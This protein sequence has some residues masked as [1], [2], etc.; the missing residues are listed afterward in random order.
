MFEPDDRLLVIYTDGYYEL[1]DT[2]Q[3]RR[4][5]IEKIALVE[6]FTAEKV[7]T[8]VYL[9][10]DKG[11]FNVKRFKIETSTTNTKFFFIKEADGN[12]IITVTTVPEPILAVHTGRGQ[13]VRSAKFKIAK[14]VDIMGW[15]AIGAK[16]MDYSKTIE[17][18]W[19]KPDPVEQSELFD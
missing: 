8:A 2:E 4:F 19:I 7:I 1:C 11:Q 13:Q 3:N 6:K 10:S 15:K 12:R 9:D 14:M 17:M 5:D 18:Q 16:L